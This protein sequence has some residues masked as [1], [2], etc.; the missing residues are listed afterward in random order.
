[1]EN[2]EKLDK[3]IKE[4][5]ELIGNILNNFDKLSISFRKINSRINLLD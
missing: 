5:K 2:K 1:M 3:E 4:S